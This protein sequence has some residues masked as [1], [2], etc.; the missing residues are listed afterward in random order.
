MF[1]YEQISGHLVSDVDAHF[2]AIG[3][4]GAAE[5]RN[6]PAYQNVHNVGPIPQGFYTIQ[7]PFDSPTHGRYAMHLEPSAENEMFG[8]SAFLIHGDYIE[9]PGHASEGCI[10]L[11]RTARESIWGS[12]DHKLQV[13]RG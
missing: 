1:I 2:L 9:N 12:G 13:V 5:G 3:Y 8:R 7:E 11:P 4:S 6:S 10:I